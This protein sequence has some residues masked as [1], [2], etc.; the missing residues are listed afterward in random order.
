[1][2]VRFTMLRLCYTVSPDAGKDRRREEK[3]TTE[4][5][6]VGWHHQLNGHEFTQAPGIGDGLGGLACCSPWRCKVLDTT[7]QLN[8]SNSNLGS[9]T[10]T[11]HS[12]NH[13]YGLEGLEI[14]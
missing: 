6:M 10:S 9:G 1:M 3:G 5:E 14:R 2:S 7:G 13:K 8:N 12:G 11:A 4:A